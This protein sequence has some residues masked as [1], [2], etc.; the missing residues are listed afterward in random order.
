V[1]SRSA[2]RRD[3]VTIGGC[4]DCH[5]PMQQGQR[6]MELDLSGGFFLRGPWGEVAS[7]NI[8]QAPSGIPYY[9]ESLFSAMSCAR[10]GSRRES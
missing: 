6:M 10:A 5:T 4:R 7:A 8:T 1:G 2:R 3:L 9:D